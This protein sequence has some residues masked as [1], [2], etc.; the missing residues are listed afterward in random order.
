MVPAKEVGRLETPF[1]ATA[2]YA[3]LAPLTP[4]AA[5]ASAAETAP[6]CAQVPDVD[7]IQVSAPVPADE[8]PI[9]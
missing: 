1:Y 2:A 4:V 9:A 7:A 6:D 5:E 3:H 8:T